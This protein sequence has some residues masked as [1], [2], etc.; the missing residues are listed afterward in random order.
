MSGKLKTEFNLHDI[1]KVDGT[2]NVMVKF[3]GINCME[4]RMKFIEEK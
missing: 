3:S 2:L 4:A 1:V